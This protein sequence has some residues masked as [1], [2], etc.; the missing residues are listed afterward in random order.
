VLDDDDGGE[1]RRAVAAARRGPPA[2]RRAY[3]RG[4]LAEEQEVE[5]ASASAIF[6]VRDLLAI[7]VMAA[8]RDAGRTPG[9]DVAVV[10]T[11]IFPTPHGYRSPE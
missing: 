4:G 10:G 8:L 6:A 1:S 3:A 5:D 7:D 9:Q 2:V 11:T